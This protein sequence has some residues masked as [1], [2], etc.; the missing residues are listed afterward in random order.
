MSIDSLL[1]GEPSPQ[2]TGIPSISATPT[3]EPLGPQRLQLEEECVALAQAVTR[4]EM[5]WGAN[6]SAK[7]GGYNLPS[8]DSLPISYRSVSIY[9]GVVALCHSPQGKL[10]VPPPGR[11][12]GQRRSLSLPQCTH[13]P[14][15][16]WTTRA[17]RQASKRLCSNIPFPIT[18]PKNAH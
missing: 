2:L 18:Q 16:G 15:K 4:R 11:S 14:A 13:S 12:P 10:P 3:S 9:M 7:A 1:R 8:Q 6:S 5:L 17:C